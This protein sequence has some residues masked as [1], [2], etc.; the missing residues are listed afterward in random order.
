MREFTNMM[1]LVDEVN[2]MVERQ[3]A[4]MRRVSARDLG[5]DMRCGHAYVDEAM[6]CIV[7]DES[8]ARS[9]NYYGGFE[10]IADEDKRQLGDYVVYLNSNDRVQDALDSLMEKDGL[11]EEETADAE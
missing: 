5:L 6:E 8:R 7:V 3:V 11:C 10:Y 4:G 9:F 1:D 2:D